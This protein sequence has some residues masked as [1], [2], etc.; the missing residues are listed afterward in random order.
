MRIAAVTRDP[1]NG[2]IYTRLYTSPLIETPDI[3]FPGCPD[4]RHWTL[5][6]IVEAWPSW[7]PPFGCVCVWWL[8]AVGLRGHV[9]EAHAICTCNLR[10]SHELLMFALYLH[11][12][13]G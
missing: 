8:S 12:G 10:P 3:H 5:Y 9:W 7:L 6:Y 13:M 4:P 2:P 1:C 11:T